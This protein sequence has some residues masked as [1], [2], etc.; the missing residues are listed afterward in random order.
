MELDFSYAVCSV[1]RWSHRRGS[2]RRAA[3]RS[4]CIAKKPAFPKILALAVL[5][6]LFASYTVLF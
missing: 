1:R 5:T 3:S 6:D 2:G 4:P